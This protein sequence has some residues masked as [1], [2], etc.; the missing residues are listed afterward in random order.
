MDIEPI[1][2]LLS[3][4]G[5]LPGI[6]VDVEA[7]DRFAEPDE[8]LFTTEELE[9]CAAQSAPAQS[10]AGRWCGKEAVSK[11]CAKYLQLSLREIEI[12]AEPSGRPIVL[13]PARATEIGLTVEVSIAHAGGTAV[14]VAV[15]RQMSSDGDSQK[16]SQLQDH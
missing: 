16:P 12:R 2:L 8:R 6:G 11:A 15:A 14:A 3:R 1:A 4:V 5:I 7:V 9:Y 10:R 13:L